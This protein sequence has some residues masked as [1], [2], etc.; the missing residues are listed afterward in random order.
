MK[1]LAVI[2]FLLSGTMI[3]NAQIEDVK[4]SKTVTANQIY[5]GILS[6]TSASIDSLHVAGYSNFRLG[7][8]VTWR[9]YKGIA[10]KSMAMMEVGTGNNSWAMNQFSLIINPWEKLK[11]TVGNQGTLVTE[12]RPYPVTAGGQ[13]ETKTESWVPGSAPSAKASL[14]ISKNFSTGAA[15]AYRNNQP[16]YQAMVGFKSFKLSGLYRG[17]DQK[18]GAFLTMKFW[19]IY[20]IMVW[21]Q[22][23]VAGNFFQ[24]SLGRNND[25]CFVSD[26]GFD[27]SKDKF[28]MVRGEWGLLKTFQAPYVAGLIGPSYC[29]ETRSVNVYLHL[30]LGVK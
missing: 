11:I 16:E 25:F 24:I 23:E 19:R 20:D 28:E 2:L 26:T 30:H 3:A 17:R 29:Y 4:I 13:F 1:K 12:Q 8:A 21:R 7:G 9:P 10:V 15:I 22:N 6:W 14:A 18:F 27:L 5:A